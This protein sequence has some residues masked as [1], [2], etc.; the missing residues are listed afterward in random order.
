VTFPYPLCR[1]D[2][3]GQCPLTGID[4]LKNSCCADGGADCRGNPVN[5]GTGVKFQEETDIL[6]FDGI[7]FR[8]YYNSDR[9]PRPR[10]SFSGGWRGTYDRTVAF[11]PGDSI[12]TAVVYRH[13]GRGFYFNRTGATWTSD[14]DVKLTLQQTTSGG[15]PT[16]WIVTDEDDTVE[17]Y[18]AAGKL[19]SIARHGVII[20][21]LAYVNDKLST[22]T[23]LGGRTLTF[24][25]SSTTGRL[26]SIATQIGTHVTYTYSGT[27]Q[28]EYAQYADGTSR[29]YHYEES[30]ADAATLLTGISTVFG[31]NEIRVATWDYDS[32]GRAILSVNGV[33]GSYRNRVEIDYPTATPNL[34][35]VRKYTSSNAFS[36]ETATIQNVIGVARVVNTDT[37]CPGCGSN[38]I[39][40][41]TFDSNGFLDTTTDAR[42]TVTD[43]TFNVRGLQDSRIDVANATC[44]PAPCTT[45]KRTTTT[46]WDTNTRMPLSVTRQNDS[47]S[48]V[49]KMLY[50]LNS[51][52]DTVASCMQD[53]SSSAAC[54]A[55]GAPATGQRR[56]VNTYCD[57]VNLTPPGAIGP[58]D[59]MAL[60]CPF[61]GRLRRVDG[62]RTDV[63]DW[64]TLEYRLADDGS[65]ATG[66]TC[67]YRKGDL[68]R[69]VNA[70]G[71][72]TEYVS[73]DKMGRP[74]RIKDA[75]GVLTDMTYHARGWLAT[76]TVRANALGSPSSDD[77]I[78]TLIYDAVGNMTQVTQP[79]GSFTSYTY[80]TLLRLT[81]ITDSLGN[82]IQYTLDDAGNRT[83][84]ETK[85]SS[86]TVKRVLARE[87]DTLS[88]LQK[89]YMAPYAN[90]PS[91]P[92]AKST[93][94]T[95]DAN[96]NVDTVTNPLNSVDDNDYDPLNRLVRT[97]QNVGGINA[98]VEFQYDA[99]DNLVR[100]NDPK[101][102]DTTYTY[103]GLNNLTQLVSPDTGTT[104]HTYNIAGNRSTSTDARGRT[105]TY[106]YDSLGRLTSI[107]YPTSSLNVALYYDVAQADCTTGET[108]AAGRMVRMTDESGETR[109]CYDRRGNLVRKVQVTDG[110]TMVTRWTYTKADRVATMTYPSNG[111]VTYGRD[112]QGRIT[113]ISL[114]EASIGNVTLV[115]AVTYEPFGPV[116]SITYGN[117]RTL[118][119]V[120]DQNYW[121]DALNSGSGSVNL[122]FGTND[123]GSITSIL[124]SG[125]RSDSRNYEY[126]ALSRLTHAKQLSSPIEVFTYDATGNRLS[127][128]DAGGTAAYT[129]GTSNHRLTSVG[130]EG[131]SYDA[132]GN[133]TNGLVFQGSGT[134]DDR[135]RLARVDEAETGIVAIY[136]YNANGERVYKDDW[137]NTK[138]RLFTYDQLGHLIAERT[139]SAG[140]SGKQDTVH[141]IVWLDDLP[142]ATFRKGA[143]EYIEPDHLGTPRAVV[144]PVRN[145]PVWRWDIVGPF[146][147]ST[148]VFGDGLAFNDPDGDGTPFEFN[149]RFPGQYLD[150]ETGLHYNYFRDYE[151]GVGRYVESD[152][153]GLAGGVSTYS[154]AHAKPI[155]GTDA[156]GLFASPVHE[157]IT[158]QVMSSKLSCSAEF[159]DEV[160]EESVNYDFI[161]GSQEPENAFTHGMRGPNQSKED[162]QQAMDAWI[163]ERLSKCTAK[164]LAYA[165]H[166]TQDTYSRS[167]SDF[168]EFGGMLDLSMLAHG[169]IDMTPT[170][171]DF[172]GAAFATDQLFVR[173]K[174][175][176]PCVCNR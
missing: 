125:A 112:G 16:G 71:H 67:A 137:F 157:S 42:G 140:G 62:P 108:F 145:V 148:A 172:T 135:G 151:P 44:S 24:T 126:D 105:A 102:L 69:M 114:S 98:E 82:T 3:N 115:S 47:G 161:P 92:G 143:Y 175:R 40:T 22:V 154:Y 15:S 41:R 149:L 9:I 129:Y 104:I 122:D 163:D 63:N 158:Q 80:D 84:E 174:Q 56:T 68:W 54:S 32:S 7:E 132:A 11:T 66:G 35:I 26:Q 150:T 160:I 29:R 166:A 139:S 152:P 53:P 73:Y 74:T 34:R 50:A 119:R 124:A 164:D 97:L 87:Y 25:H 106:S 75:N 111:V 51:R 118:T 96:R 88:R 169:I 116:A 167:H 21:Q 89:L 94:Y 33:V 8:R 165:M 162:A 170:Q 1:K 37:P 121:I 28:L 90:N 72:V 110:S 146:V 13:D 93:N 173:F 79:D 45:A 113:S 144:D 70:T 6:P 39:T 4:P 77:A 48:V 128:T 78:T 58:G 18:D 141:E 2:T 176:C 12:E 155:I 159:V 168:Q 153:V 55:S 100:I 134:Y 76:R 95:Y 103:D 17:T 10:Q 171:T 23:S 107:T 20:A 85:L 61:V 81:G 19:L 109:F 127:K 131:R 101:N 64:T 43:Y 65:C 91:A 59:N 117:G 99:R 133:T 83:K 49:S 120:Y 138:N 57:A 14:S 38:F 5:I 52:G 46:Q 142:V 130:S 123:L 86:G 60:G 36:T 31:A 136:R 27:G 156:L 30:G 147:T